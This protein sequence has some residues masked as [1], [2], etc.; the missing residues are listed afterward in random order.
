MGEGIGDH[1]IRKVVASTIGSC[2]VCAQ[3]LDEWAV[4]IIGHQDD[5]WFFSVTCHKCDTQ[6]L[7]AALV[8]DSEPVAF[9]EVTG[10]DSEPSS[11]RRIDVDDVRAVHR[12]LGAFNGDFQSLFR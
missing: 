2:G 12:F 6:V 1:L 5:L 4:S 10:R 7:A 8:R 9:G 11:Q 3:Q